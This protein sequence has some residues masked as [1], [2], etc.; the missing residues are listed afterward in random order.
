M[1]G[2]MY[3]RE[4]LAHIIHPLFQKYYAD[5]AILFGAYGCLWVLM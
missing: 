5:R 4:E 2:Y 3:F 1:F